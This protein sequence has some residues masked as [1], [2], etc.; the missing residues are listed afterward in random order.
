MPHENFDVSARCLDDKRL[1][2]QRVEAFQIIKAIRGDYADSGAW[3]NQ[4][5]YAITVLRYA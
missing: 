4:V 2:T 1:G 5:R 3:V